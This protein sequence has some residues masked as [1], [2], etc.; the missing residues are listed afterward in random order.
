MFGPVELVNDL[1]PNS[2]VSYSQFGTHHFTNLDYSTDL[3]PTSEYVSAPTF[4]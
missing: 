3:T 1:T 2:P 4:S